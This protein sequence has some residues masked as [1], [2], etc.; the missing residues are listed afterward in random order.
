MNSR[1][2]AE[3]HIHHYARWDRFSPRPLG[4]D[5]DISFGLYGFHFEADRGSLVG[6][7]FVEYAWPAD[8]DVT[9]IAGGWKVFRALD[10]PMIGGRF[11]HGGGVFVLDDAKRTI[12]LTR[13][14]PMAGLSEYSLRTQMD[15]LRAVAA[16]WQLHWLFRV[17]RIVHG[18]EP[19]PTMFTPW[20][21]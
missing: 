19:R 7:V 8:A 13:E 16:A 3:T 14:F 1:Q 20:V 9:A 18:W 15:H 6:R 17:A 12:C 4:A 21:P 10:D 2:R 5:D 11:D